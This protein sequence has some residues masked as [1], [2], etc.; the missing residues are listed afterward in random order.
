MTLD[1]IRKQFTDF[2]KKNGHAVVSSSSLLPDDPSVLL[3]T[4]G[5]QQFKKY[6]TG[7]RD[8]QKDFSARRT[9]SAQ[10]C[11]RT[12]DIEEVGDET[13]NTFFEMLGNFSFGD[14]FK[15]DAIR[16]AYE[17]LTERIGI[18]P[19]RIHATVF[20]GDD[21]VPPDEESFRIWNEEIGIPADRIKKYGKDDNFWG[22]TGAEG[23]CGPT[24]EIYVD[25]IE[26]W[27]LVFNEFFYP[28]TREEL[29]SGAPGKTLT[30]LSQNGVD[31]GMGLERLAAVMQGTKNIYETGAF[32]PIM[33]TLAAHAPHLP[34][35]AGRIIADH[36]RASAFLIAD[37]LR[38]A[39]KDAEYIL[40]RLIRKTLALRVKYDIHADLFPILIQRISE[41]YGDA[42]PELRKEDKIISVLEEEGKKFQQAIARGIKEIKKRDY[43]TAD[44]AFRLYEAFGIPFEITLELVPE[45][46]R[47]TLRRE[48]FEKKVAEHKKI[49]RA[50]AGKKF[51]GHG[52]IFDTGELKA[53][54]KDELARV[55]RLHTATHLLQQALRNIFGSDI[56]QRGSDITAERT[57]FDF[58]FDRK[59]TSEELARVE[60]EVNRVINMHLPVQ[61][62]EM[63]KE[64][65]EK[66]GALF[67]FGEK[68]PERITI[69][70]VGPSLMEAYSKEFCGGPHVTNTKEI[71]KFKI[72]KEE[73]SSAGIRRIRA[74]VD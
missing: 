74:T 6:Y 52:L 13:H 68:Y 26:I 34:I 44:D 64:A 24:A 56:G 54:D 62:V 35:R 29:L 63:E 25:G 16:F 17:F 73:A 53:R 23:P 71:G 48:D 10:K 12:S 2:F 69:Y 11:F 20:K 67:F 4:A 61:C 42:Y 30:P 7:E 9:V 32:A 50:G 31:T 39:N 72:I 43:I 57:R 36:M 45:K 41:M 5:M 15:E 8:A 46:K 47:T 37:G 22:P 28:G 66:T 49:S 51:G 60:D 1:E 38:P 40:R 70:F 19:D 27:N 55:T 58:S 14:Y 65:A 33:A 21:T 3:T 59:V 18:S